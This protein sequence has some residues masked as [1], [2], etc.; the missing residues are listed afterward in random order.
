M[1]RKLNN[2]YLTIKTKTDIYDFSQDA[3]NLYYF[4]ATNQ[5]SLNELLNDTYSKYITEEGIEIYICQEPNSS[6][7]SNKKNEIVRLL[8]NLPK[9]TTIVN[10]KESNKIIYTLQKNK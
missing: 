6:D 7:D 10:K 3:F 1:K 5:D 4:T 2:Y 8:K 9:Y